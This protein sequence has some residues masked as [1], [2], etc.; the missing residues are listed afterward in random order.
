VLLAGGGVVENSGSDARNWR[1]KSGEGD[2]IGNRVYS[3][4]VVEEGY[5]AVECLLKFKGD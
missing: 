4:R 1:Q 2:R 5:S 3:L